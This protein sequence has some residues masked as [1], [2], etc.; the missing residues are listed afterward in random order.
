M[1]RR[2]MTSVAVA[3]WLAVVA[4]G[5]VEPPGDASPATPEARAPLPL[6]VALVDDVVVEGSALLLEVRGAELLKDATARVA[7]RGELDGVAVGGELMVVPEGEG[8]LRVSVPW[9]ALMGL[10]GVLEPGVFLGRVQVTLD[11]PALQVQAVGETS[12]ALDLVTSLSPLVALPERLEVHLNEE[13]RWPAT[14]LLRPREGATSLEIEGR[15]TEEGGAAREVRATVPVSLGEAGLEEAR[16]RWVADALG[17]RPGVFRGRVRV[18]NRGLRGEEGAE[19]VLREV[20]LKPTR[21]VGLDPPRASRG[22]LI[23][24]LGRGFVPADGERGMFFVAEGEFVGEDGARVVWSGEQ[25]AQWAPERVGSHMEAEIALR[26]EVGELGRLMG[27]GATPG[28]FTGSITP[29]LIDRV[30]AVWGEPWE[31]SLTIAPTRQVVWVRLSQGYT[32]ALGEFGLR[33]VEPEIRAVIL[34]TLRRHFEGV[35]VIFTDRAP[36]GW[37]EYTVVEVGGVDPNGAGLLG[38]DNS[39]GH[40]VGNL[41]LDDVIGGRNA[42]SLERGEHGFGGVFVSSFQQFSPT[43]APESLL[44]SERFDALFGPFMPALSGQPVD[45]REATAASGP[46]RL[47]LEQ[48]VAAMGALI[49]H[50]ISHEVGHALGLATGLD[51]VHNATDE[52]GAIMDEGRWRPFEERCGLQESRFNARNRRYL[53]TI[54]PL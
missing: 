38:L 47:A 33:N 12:V 7:L 45:A 25:S 42:E 35:N 21:V 5:C 39:E 6:E 49:G 24:V 26:T 43:L 11:D 34:A 22:E 18:V 2:L 16:V 36:Q 44:A 23:R 53:E 13:Q 50:T 15:F 20:R 51:G 3:A 4:A 29:V 37:R 41:R 8:D 46:R 48:A 19:T 17:V 1:R 32:E 9:S 30:G 10:E 28:V 27:F 40:D 14:G 54:L 52:P 31:G